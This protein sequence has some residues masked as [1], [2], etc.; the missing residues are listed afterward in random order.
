[1][2]SNLDLQLISGLP[3]LVRA[4]DRF[5]ALVTLRNT[6]AQAPLSE[7]ENFPSR[8]KALTAGH[9]AYSLEFSHYEPAPPPLQ[10]KLVE[11]HKP[12]HVEE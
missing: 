4:G 1:M 6:T 8:L 7:M 11:Q 5:S 2:R 3:P 9:G 12:A 10:A